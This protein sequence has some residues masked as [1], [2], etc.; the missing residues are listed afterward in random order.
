MKIIYRLPAFI[1]VLLP[2]ILLSCADR[3]Q[4]PEYRS[5]SVN[6]VELHY[7]EQGSGEPVILIH[8]SLADQSY[9]EISN[10]V[11][12]LSVHHHVINYSRRYNHPNQNEPGMNHSPLV[13][14]EDLARM[15]DELGTGPVHLVGHSYGAYTALVFALDH[16]A[17]IRSLVLAEP[18]IL[19]W[20]PDIAG[21]EGIEEGFMAGVWHPMAEAFRE[22][23]EAG[24]EFTSKWYFKLPFSEIEPE[25]Q[26]SFKT[27]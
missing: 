25:W 24:L 13:E 3:E 2:L 21:G 15:L 9:W 5:V 26:T 20:L 19:P 10:Q 22:S 11:E 27:T 12:P 14:A 1:F 23:D 17:K 8:G 18:P 4:T 6:G 7:T 16:P